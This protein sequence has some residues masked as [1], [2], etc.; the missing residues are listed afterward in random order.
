MK[1]QRERDRERDRV[2]NEEVAP[3]EERVRKLEATQLATQ[4]ELT[5]LRAGLRSPSSEVPAQ[6]SGTA[7]QDLDDAPLINLNSSNPSRTNTVRCEKQIP[8]ENST[9]NDLYDP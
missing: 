7:S 3:L 8:E 6:L 1:L 5:T 9:F 2:R 4:L